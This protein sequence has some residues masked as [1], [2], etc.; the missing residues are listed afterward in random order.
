MKNW[1]NF[2]RLP[3][4]GVGIQG[5]ASAERSSGRYAQ[6]TPQEVSDYQDRVMGSI[7]DLALIP[8]KTNTFPLRG[9]GDL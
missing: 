7:A 1:N 3:M 9:R 8:P 2:F 6:M 4:A 5:V